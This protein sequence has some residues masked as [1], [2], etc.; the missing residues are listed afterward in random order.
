MALVWN[1][2]GPGCFYCRRPL[3]I[4]CAR[5]DHFIPRSKGGPDSLENRRAACKECDVSKRD[6]WPWDF[7]P[8]RFRPPSGDAGPGGVPG[9]GTAA[10]TEVV[11]ADGEPTRG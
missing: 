11:G 3:S 6:Q 1:R 5:L 2:D 8:D 7:M 9:G 10:R 4:E